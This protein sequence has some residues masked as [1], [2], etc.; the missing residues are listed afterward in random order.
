MGGP[1]SCLKVMWQTLLTLHGKPT[2][3]EEQLWCGVREC[4]GVGEGKKL[5]SKKR[6]DCLK[7]K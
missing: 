2:L 5:G 4:G 7:N 3:S 6:K 1:L